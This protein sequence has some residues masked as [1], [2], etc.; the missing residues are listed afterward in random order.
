MA[1]VPQV[2]ARGSVARMSDIDW[3]DEPEP[4]APEPRRSKPGR[5]AGGRKVGRAFG[6]PPGGHA[7]EQP[8]EPDWMSDPGK[9]PKKPPGR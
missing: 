1:N 2:A 7:R 3:T 5:T 4:E 8:P 6:G 9:L